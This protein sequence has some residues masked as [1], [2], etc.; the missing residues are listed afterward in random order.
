MASK[1]KANRYGDTKISA[2]S[3]HPFDRDGHMTKQGGSYKNWNKR[4][5]ILKDR[6]LYYYKT[7]KDT[8]FTGRIDL[9]ANSVVKEEPGIKKSPNIFSI[10]TSRRIFFMYPD[11]TEEVKLW[12]DSIQ[13]AID[14]AKGISSG[15]S[16]SISGMSTHQISNGQPHSYDQSPNQYDSSS[17]GSRKPES[18]NV[19][20]SGSSP[21]PRVRLSLAKGVVNF[22]KDPESKVLEFWQ[23]WSESIASKDDLTSGMAIEFQ[24]ATSADMQKIDLANKWT[25]KYIHSK[26][27]RFLLECRSS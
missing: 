2:A 12:L 27:G 6:Y 23:I 20:S 16:S 25:S 14:K 9:E 8:M 22:L 11:K 19:N 4:Y 7:P 13:K 5:F 26:D 18:A 1:K 10:S 24:V 3:L 21:S 17:T 15:D